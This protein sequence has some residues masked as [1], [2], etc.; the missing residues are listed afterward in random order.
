MGKLGPVVVIQAGAFPQAG[1]ATVVVV[2]LTRY[3]R[4]RL[5]LARGHG[6]ARRHQSRRLEQR[7]S[8]RPCL[9]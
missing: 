2:S 8:L 1:L 5:G 3:A 9:Y 6:D 7:I 4:R